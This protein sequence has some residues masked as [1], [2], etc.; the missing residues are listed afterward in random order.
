MESVARGKVSQE[1]LLLACISGTLGHIMLG[2]GCPC[3]F[4][5]A[6]RWLQA[7]FSPTP[8]GEDAILSAVAGA[9]FLSSLCVLYAAI[10]DISWQTSG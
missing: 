5:W 6:I 4:G 2:I 9:S 8:P 7:K 1:G 3:F 10:E